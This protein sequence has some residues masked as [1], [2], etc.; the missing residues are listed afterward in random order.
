LQAHGAARSETEPAD[1]S[2]QAIGGGDAV[3]IYGVASRVIFAHE[4][5]VILKEFW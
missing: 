2:G 1:V 5:G 3:T 4:I